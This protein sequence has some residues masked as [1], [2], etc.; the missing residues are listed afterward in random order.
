MAW[1]PF[2]RAERTP[3]IWFSASTSSPESSASAGSPV[4]A[5]AARALS[6]A[7]PAKVRS[8]SAGS[9]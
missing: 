5:T 9:G 1:G 4:A 6:S 7:L 2:Q 8:V 3:G